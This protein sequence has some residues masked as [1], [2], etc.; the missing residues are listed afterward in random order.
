[1]LL[2]NLLSGLKVSVSTVT[3]TC[4][5]DTQFTCTNGRCIPKLWKCDW[6]DDCGDRSDEMP[7][8]D[9]SEFENYFR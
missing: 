5:P 2:T 6:D 7:E 8:E 3:R 9:C 1:M 4:N